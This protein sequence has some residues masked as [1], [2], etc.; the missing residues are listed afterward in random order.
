VSVRVRT[1]SHGRL[2]RCS[3]APAPPTP[4]SIWSCFAKDASYTLPTMYVYV[5]I[6]LMNASVAIVIV[7]NEKNISLLWT[8]DFPPVYFTDEISANDGECNNFG[9]VALRGKPSHG[10][11][12]WQSFLKDP[13]ITHSGTFILKFIQFS[14]GLR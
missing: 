2:G 14:H 1:P 6:E 4:C 11:C 8:K 9:R 7:D 12:H 10:S 3:P 5:Q 13:I